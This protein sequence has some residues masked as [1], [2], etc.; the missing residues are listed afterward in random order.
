MP[1]SATLKDAVRRRVDSPREKQLRRP[2]Q[3]RTGGD[4]S[5]GRGNSAGRGSSGDDTDSDSRS[6]DD[7]DTDTDPAIMRYTS[8]G[9][10]TG[11]AMVED[12][13]SNGDRGSESLLGDEGDDYV[14]VLE[15]NLAKNFKKRKERP[16][17]T[18]EERQ[19]CVHKRIC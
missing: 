11:K 17:D 3:S 14:E 6:S 4:G 13:G 2:Q 1:K 5:R 9:N 15:S 19:V 10:G 18:E 12:D 8:M 7:D 16:E